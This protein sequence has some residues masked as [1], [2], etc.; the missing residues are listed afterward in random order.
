MRT[1]QSFNPL[2]DRYHFDLGPCSIGKGFAHIDTEEDASNFGNW[3]NPFTLTMVCFAE[4]DISEAKCDTV[5]EFLTELSEMASFYCRLS[6]DT[7]VNEE[8]RA[9]LEQIGAGGFLR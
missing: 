5:E 3:C 7:G 2:T 8:L 9:R 6:I 1:I 4:G